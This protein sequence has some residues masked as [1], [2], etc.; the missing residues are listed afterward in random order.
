MLRTALLLISLACL[1][2]VAA[3]D[4]NEKLTDA[5]S[6]TQIKEQYK[7]APALIP[8]LEKFR[9]FI[10][11]TY[12]AEFEGPNGQPVTD[13]SHWERALNGTAIRI[14]HSINEGEYGGETLI[15]YDKN[16]A[17]LRFY[18]FTTAGF[19]TQG[20][21]HFEGGAFISTETIKGDA[22][23]ITHVVSNA[24]LNSDGTLTLQATFFKGDT[25]T[26][27]HT[28]H[29]RPVENLMPVFR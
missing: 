21:A 11:K 5:H 4:A 19:Y 9:P 18:Y 8:A 28:A 14:M 15:F 26:S 29:Y 22:Q 13:V 24:T 10:G 23:G 7:G 6:K 20:A 16:A 3:T 25:A 17:S 27:G 2:A 12:Q 1:P